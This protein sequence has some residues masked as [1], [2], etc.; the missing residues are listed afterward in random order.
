MRA[1]PELERK[2]QLNGSSALCRACLLYT[3]RRSGKVKGN[4]ARE[5]LQSTETM[6][7]RTTKR[8]RTRNADERRRRPQTKK[9]ERTLRKDDR[10]KK[11]TGKPEK[12]SR[13][14]KERLS[15]VCLRRVVNARNFSYCMQKIDE[16]LGAKKQV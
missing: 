12:T 4:A 1:L 5:R 10:E 14:L 7:R 16:F 2:R 11:N 3:G 9:K 6:K 8:G 15:S 13:R